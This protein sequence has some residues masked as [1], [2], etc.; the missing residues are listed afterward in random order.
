MAGVVPCA[1]NKSPQNGHWHK[2]EAPT[3][4]AG[5]SA[6]T[7]ATKPNTASQKIHGSSTESRLNPRSRPTYPPKV[8][9]LGLKR[10]S[11]PSAWRPN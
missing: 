4:Q 9:K 7:I 10:E 5:S 1:S 3:H 6:H 11:D 2:A 8:N